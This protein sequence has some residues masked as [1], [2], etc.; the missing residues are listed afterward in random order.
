MDEEKICVGIL[1]SV[2]VV[3]F[4]VVVVVVM[5]VV[6]VVV[7]VRVGFVGVWVSCISLCIGQRVEF[8][9]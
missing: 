9:I 8:C 5:F 3:M 1:T 7:V 6:V 4:V 2:V